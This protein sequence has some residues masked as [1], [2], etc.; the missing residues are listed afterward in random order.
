[1]KRDGT[2]FGPSPGRAQSFV[3]SFVLLRL[4]W[5][6]LRWC[7][8]RRGFEASMRVFYLA[9]KK[10]LVGGFVTVMLLL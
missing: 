5:R 3:R 10:M 7:F 9:V 1:M 4:E 2:S 8:E 6:I